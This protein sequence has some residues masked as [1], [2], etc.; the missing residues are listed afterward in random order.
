MSRKPPV[1]VFISARDCGKCKEF[2]EK[3]WPSIKKTVEDAKGKIVLMEVDL[4]KMSDDL[5]QHLPADL[6]RYRG[7]YPIFMLFTAES[8]DESKHLENVGIFN[9]RMRPGLN[10]N[11]ELTGKEGWDKLIP[12]ISDKL[13]EY[14]AQKPKVVHATEPNRS[15]PP[16]NVSFVC[17]EFIGQTRM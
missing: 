16:P 12:W 10:A 15:P 1:L 11:P 3:S 4:G 14:N 17:Q 13:K 2:R 8:W 5:P 7:W 9:G 6:D